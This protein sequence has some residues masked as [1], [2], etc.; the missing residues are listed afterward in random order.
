MRTINLLTIL[1]F[2]ILLLSLGGVTHAQQFAGTGQPDPIRYIVVPEIPGPNQ[3]VL[4]DI[5][6]VGSFL[7]N[8]TITWENNGKTVSSGVGKTTYSFTTGGIGQVVVIHITIDSS[9]QGVIQHDVVFNPSLVNLVWEADTSV[10]NFYLGKPLYSAGSKLIVVAFPTVMSNG[11]FVPSNNLSFQWSRKDSL[12]PAQSGMGKNTFSFDGDQLQKEE[13][14]G[15]DVYL[16]ATKVGHST[17]VVPTSDTAV[18]FYSLDP[19]RGELLDQGL[20]GSQTLG[21]KEITLKAEPYFFSNTSRNRGALTYLWT[22]N[23]RE[24]IGPDSAKGILTLRQTGSGAGAVQIG[25]SVQNTNTDTFIQEADAVLDLA[26]GKQTG[27]ALSSF[28]GL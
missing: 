14:V 2:S 18:I 22:L 8:S 27:S 26:F 16:G 6:G 1:F 11:S 24:T 7:G 5:E 10:P 4:I 12:I 25:A 17:L 20:I 9:T 19:L 21:G 13:V 15:V 28:F 23:G 3:S